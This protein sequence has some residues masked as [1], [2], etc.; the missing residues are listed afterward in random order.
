MNSSNVSVDQGFAEDE[1]GFEVDRLY[2]EFN[3]LSVVF[4]QSSERFLKEEIELE[5]E[6]RRQAPSSGVA[7]PVRT[8]S[9]RPSSF[10]LHPPLALPD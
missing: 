9:L 5:E 2:E 10:T 4:R 6:E 7:P 1:D 8:K 3:T